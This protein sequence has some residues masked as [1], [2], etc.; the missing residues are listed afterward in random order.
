MLRLRIAAVTG[1]A[2]VDLI[3]TEASQRCMLPESSVSTT[4]QP[5]YEAVYE[6]DDHDDDSD[7]AEENRF[8]K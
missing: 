5:H 6:P 4:D 3:G 2:G 1:L 7:E 8:D